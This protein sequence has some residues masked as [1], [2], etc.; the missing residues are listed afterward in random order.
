M[1]DFII[2]YI[3]GVS[4]ACLSEERQAKVGNCGFPFVLYIM[5]KTIKLPANRLCYKLREAL[6]RSVSRVLVM[7]QLSC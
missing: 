7:L 3:V 6:F 2:Y 5:S 4:K 1:F